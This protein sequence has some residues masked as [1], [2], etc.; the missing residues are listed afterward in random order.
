MFSDF[1]V[2][3]VCQ[4]S[5]FTR[6]PAKVMTESMMGVGTPAAFPKAEMGTRPM[7]TSSTIRRESSLV[8]AMM[9]AWAVDRWHRSD[10]FSACTW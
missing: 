7:G 8:G 2:R 9:P 10:I 4:K 1:R 5:C 6:A 3:P